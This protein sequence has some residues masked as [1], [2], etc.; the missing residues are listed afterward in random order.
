M[1]RFLLVSKFKMIGMMLNVVHGRVTV[2][3][4]NKKKAN[5]NI[6]QRSLRAC[7]QGE[8]VTLVLG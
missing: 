6:K 8:R 2:Q 1:R 7:L 4:K 5:E 3:N